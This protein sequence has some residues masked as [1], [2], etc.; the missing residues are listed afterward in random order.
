MQSRNGLISPGDGFESGD[1]RLGALISQHE[2]M[3]DSFD[4]GI[5]SQELPLTT[6]SPESVARAMAVALNQEEVPLLSLRERA[7]GGLG[8]VV[9][10]GLVSVT[11]VITAASAY[12]KLRH[13]H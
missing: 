2:L 6:A 9:I 10:G 8:K 1:A 3:D 13:S 4:G 11:A 12:R 7:T 5:A